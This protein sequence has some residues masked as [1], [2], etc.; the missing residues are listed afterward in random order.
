MSSHPTLGA[1]LAFLSLEQR[2]LLRLRLIHPRRMLNVEPLRTKDL[3]DCVVIINDYG[4]F[5]LIRKAAELSGLEQTS[6]SA[7]GVRSHHQRAF[8]ET[9]VGQ[10]RECVL[11]TSLRTSGQIDEVVVG[12]QLLRA[13]EPFGQHGI[14]GCVGEEGIPVLGSGLDVVQTMT[15]VGEDA[16]DVENGPWH[17]LSLG[18]RHQ[19][20]AGNVR[21]ALTGRRSTVG[22][23]LRRVLA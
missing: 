12:A 11:P 16:V 18:R 13:G 8:G 7:I 1:S 15:N 17:G 3:D 19:T 9:V 6:R 4:D 5:L 14:A 20:E 22:P 2:V 10:P 23:G 21:A